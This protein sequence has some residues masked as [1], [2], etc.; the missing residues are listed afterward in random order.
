MSSSPPEQP[1]L[2]LE[3]E[4]SPRLRW[5]VHALAWAACLH[6]RAGLTSSITD[7]TKQGWEGPL[8]EA[9]PAGV[10]VGGVVQSR[11]HTADLVFLVS[12]SRS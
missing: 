9:E 10:G 11:P 2:R 8:T 7:A 6:E 1:G 4:L 12:L 3:S 5:C